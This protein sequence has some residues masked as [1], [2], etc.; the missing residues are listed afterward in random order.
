M[1]MN[2]AEV[3]R[4][5]EEIARVK[6]LMPRTASSFVSELGL[7]VQFREAAGMERLQVGGMFRSRVD[8]GRDS[9]SEPWQIRKYRPG[10]W[11]SLVAPTLTLVHWL[12]YREGVTAL[13][14]GDFE[15]AVRYFRETGDL[16]LPERI[17]SI[18]DT[19][20]LGRVL[21]PLSEH[22]GEW[23]EKEGQDAEQRL[24]SFLDKNPG[25]ATVWQAL[26]GVYVGLGRYRASLDSLG[27][28]IAI[29]PYEAEF[30]REAALQYVT[31]VK[32]AVEP[33][34][35]LGL[36]GKGMTD[37]NLEAIGCSYEEAHSACKEHLE[38]V[39]ESKRP[40]SERYKLRAR[41]ILAW[42]ARVNTSDGS[43]S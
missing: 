23:D 3:I 43:Y 32:N 39:V 26:A 34:L 13:V 12:A 16:Q 25:Q 14:R 33:D 22:R 30:H 17:E 35:Q 41:G 31:A 38:M 24:L 11:E 29:A 18:P 4:N 6:Q 21:D 19:S 27:K 42:C 1:E 20:F 2:Q 7:H 28:A 10:H 40:D 8:L 15:Y 36:V 5:L 37:C 9:H